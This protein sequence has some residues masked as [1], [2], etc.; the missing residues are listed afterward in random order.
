MFENSIFRNP[1][2]ASRRMLGTRSRL[3]FYCIF[4]LGNAIALSGFSFLVYLLTS[5]ASAE[6]G[7]AYVLMGKYTAIGLG[8]FIFCFALQPIFLAIA[9]HG[10]IQ[11]LQHPKVQIPGEDKAPD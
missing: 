11:E 5:H 6:H 9:L 3:V 1:I 4:T 10:V 8:G 7:D 2:G